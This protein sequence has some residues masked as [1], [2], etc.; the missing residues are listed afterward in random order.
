MKIQLGLLLR[1]VGLSFVYFLYPVLPPGRDV[2]P[3]KNWTHS[4]VIWPVTRILVNCV[5]DENN[6]VFWTGY[7]SGS[8]WFLSPS[9]SLSSAKNNVQSALN[10]QHVIGENMLM[11]LPLTEWRA[12]FKVPRWISLFEFPRSVNREVKSDSAYHPKGLSVNDGIA[13]VKFSLLYF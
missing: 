8:T 1:E 10:H 12:P 4:L 13:F 5:L 2:T 9:T 3:F 7:S 11:K 6:Y